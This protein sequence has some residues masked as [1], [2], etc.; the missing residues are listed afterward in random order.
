MGEDGHEQALAGEQAFA[1][2]D[3]L[4][5]EAA[6]LAAAVAEDRLHLDA[7]VHVHHAAGLGDDALAGI[8]LDLD[9]LHLVAEDLVVDL[10]GATGARCGRWRRRCGAADALELVHGMGGNPAAH[11]LGKD[12]VLA[13][14]FTGDELGAE[15]RLAERPEALTVDRHVPLFVA[16]ASSIV[17][18]VRGLYARLSAPLRPPA[19]VRNLKFRIQNSK[20]QRPLLADELEASRFVVF[21]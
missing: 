3:Q 13:V 12:V 19:A 4:V 20:F 17:Y 10:V 18:C 1:G 6:L 16:H 8:E 21:R 7:V 5:H 15:I 2:A 14:I 11:A 9:E